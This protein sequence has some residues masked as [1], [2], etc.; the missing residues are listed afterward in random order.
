MGGSTAS[1]ERCPLGQ[2]EV[3]QDQRHPELGVC[4]N[5]KTEGWK[6]NR[7]CPVAGSSH[8]NSTACQD[9]GR[10]QSARLEVG[11]VFR[12]P[13]GQEDDELAK[14]TVKALP[15]LDQAGGSLPDLPGSNRTGKSLGYPFYREKNRRRIRCNGQY[16][17]SPSRL[18]WKLKVR[19]KLSWRSGCRKVP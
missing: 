18:P 17:T 5:R 12:S 11:I 9:Q 7:A 6:S 8:A 1:E 3:F 15:C 16:S 10:G 19:R 2:R 14:G 13:M 4:R